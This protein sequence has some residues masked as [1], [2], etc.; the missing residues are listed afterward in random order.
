[1]ALIQLLFWQHLIKLHCQFDYFD[2][3]AH[4]INNYPGHSWVFNSGPNPDF[5]IMIFPVGS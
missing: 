3:S 2:I 1:M 5:P 4:S